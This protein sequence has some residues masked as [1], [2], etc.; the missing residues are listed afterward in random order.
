[1]RIL[2]VLTLLAAAGCSNSEELAKPHGPIFQL[3]TGRWQPTTQ[4]LAR[5]APIG[6]PL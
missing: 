1:V 2:L 3:N 5:P 4:D 6:K